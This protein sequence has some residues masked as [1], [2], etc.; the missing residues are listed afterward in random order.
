[1]VKVNWKRFWQSYR[2]R[3]AAREEDLFF[4][5]G[6]TVNHR[7]ISEEAFALSIDLIAS[8]LELTRRDKLLELCCGNGLMTRRLAPLVSEVQA[9]DFA[10][11]LIIRARKF[12]AAQNVSYI[13]AD[14]IVHLKHLAQTREFIP[15]KILLGDAL[16]YFEP[17]ELTEM[18]RA[19]SALT[20]NHFIFM[21][22]GVPCDELKWNFYDTP[23]RVQR[24]EQNQLRPDNTNDGIG[25]WWRKEELE[26][27]GRDLSLKV[28]V[29]EQPSPLSTFRV[30][31][32]LRTC[33]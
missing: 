26:S 33:E 30:D 32:I 16:S 2:R 29:R 13:C 1:M 22:T 3:D 25:R 10:E 4:E 18:L 5:V 12:A 28:I 8:H 17:P 21:A 14:A 15:A 20:A 31:A 23:E 11:H 7:P 19:A 6:K 24:Y 27:I 9:V